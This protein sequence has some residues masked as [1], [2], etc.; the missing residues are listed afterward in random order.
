MVTTQ[1]EQTA[2]KPSSNKGK[3]FMRTVTEVD[4]KGA[5]VRE[6]TVHFGDPEL[7]IKKGDPARKKSYCARSG[8]IKGKDDPFSPNG[9]SRAMWDCDTKVKKTA[10]P[11]LKKATKH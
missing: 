4:A 5:T 1:I 9:Q 2:V 11:A 3:K 10:G 6:K 7:S 8:G